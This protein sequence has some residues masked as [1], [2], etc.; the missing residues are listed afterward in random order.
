MLA[1]THNLHTSFSKRA[2]LNREASFSDQVRIE[3]LL[4]FDRSFN[5]LKIDNCIVDRI[6]IMNCVIDKLIINGSHIKECIEVSNSSI[7]Q[8]ELIGNQAKQINLDIEE[9]LRGLQVENN[10]C[11]LNFKNRANTLSTIRI[12]TEKKPAGRSVIDFSVFV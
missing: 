6:I 11:Q 12:E 5:V 10:E 8:I 9:S 1:T 3:P 2:N 7:R 4:F